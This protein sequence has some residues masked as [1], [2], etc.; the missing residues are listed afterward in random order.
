MGNSGRADPIPRFRDRSGQSNGNSVYTPYPSN[1]SR[2]L[3]FH[4]LGQKIGSRVHDSFCQRDARRLFLGYCSDDIKP[5]FIYHHE[6]SQPED[7][8]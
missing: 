2:N 7:E 4:I 3:G 6:G 8:A 5:G 1:W